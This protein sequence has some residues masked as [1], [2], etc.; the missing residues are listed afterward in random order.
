[1]KRKDAQ[2]AYSAVSYALQLDITIWV[3]IWRL[4]L[5]S[6]FVQFF[7]H[8]N[9]YRKSSLRCT[10]CSR[11]RL[12]SFQLLRVCGPEP[13]QIE[14][15]SVSTYLFESAIIL[16]HLPLNSNGTSKTA[17]SSALRVRAPQYCASDVGSV[18]LTVPVSRNQTDALPQ[19]PSLNRCR[20]HS[21]KSLKTAVASTPATGT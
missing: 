18:G 9:A 4:L 20:S 8:F 7:A 13:S 11:T 15:K 5:N 2:C 16:S 19:M 1:M 17:F 3:V 21:E 14:N 12:S 6:C 10:R